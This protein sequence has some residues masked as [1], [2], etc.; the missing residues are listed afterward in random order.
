MAAILQKTENISI[1]IKI[2]SH[3]VANLNQSG[4]TDI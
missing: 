1:S 4:V 2:I 3:N